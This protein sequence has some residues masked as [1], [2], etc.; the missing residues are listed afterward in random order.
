MTAKP[1]PAAEPRHLANLFLSANKA[2]HERA[3]DRLYEEGFTTISVSHSRLLRFLRRNPNGGRLGQFAE[4][5]GITQQSATYVVDYLETHGYVVRRP[6][7]GDGRAQLISFTEKGRA[8]ESILIG[9]F[10]AIEREMRA[11][12]GAEF[13]DAMR[14]VLE[15]IATPWEA[16]HGHRKTRRPA[17]VGTE[18]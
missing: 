10:E 6:D 12:H 16:G 2:M 9:E 15:E 8:A 7:P 18:R 13:I 4:W 11:R 1:V 14:A 3:W 5:A 17:E